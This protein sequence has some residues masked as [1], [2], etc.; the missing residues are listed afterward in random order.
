LAKNMEGG[1]ESESVFYTCLKIAILYFAKQI[2]PQMIVEY[3]RK[4]MPNNIKPSFAESE[5]YINKMTGTG[6]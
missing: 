2:S 6:G 3:T 1:Y 5:E 4:H